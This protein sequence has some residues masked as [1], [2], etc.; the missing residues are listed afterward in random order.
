MIA[1]I[2]LHERK[3]IHSKSGQSEGR[4]LR[5]SRIGREST[6]R[7]ARR[8]SGAYGR[9]GSDRRFTQGH[10]DTGGKWHCLIEGAALHGRKSLH[11]KRGTGRR[12]RQARIPQQPREGGG[13]RIPA[14]STWVDAQSACC[15]GRSIAHSAWTGAGQLRGPAASRPGRRP[16]WRCLLAL[17]LAAHCRRRGAGR[18][19][20]RPRV[21]RRVSRMGKCALGCCQ[22]AGGRC[23]VQSRRIGREGE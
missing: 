9:D 13:L 14:G 15:W 23:A 7:D 11:N 10:W 20:S 8:A 2:T 1:V 5:Q 6:R 4:C 16:G 19:F 3:S 12:S 22:S 21:R 18:C 17:D